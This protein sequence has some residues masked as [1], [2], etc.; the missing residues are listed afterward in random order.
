MSATALVLPGSGSAT[1][2]DLGRFLVLDQYA[3]P[4]VRLA[5]DVLGGSLLAG[6][7]AD[8]EEYGVHG[9]VAFM[10]SSLALAE[11]AERRLGAEP[12]VALGPSLGHRALTAYA[13]VLDLPDAVALAVDFA[14][15][16]AAHFADLA[17]DLVTHCV[18]RVPD[19]PMRALVR[20][21][22]ARGEWIEVAGVLDPGAYLLSLR[23]DLLGELVDRV[24]A[25]GAYS[26]R[27]MRPA[28][29]SRRF[30]GLRE[31]VAAE[32]LPRY[33]L[34]PPALPVV[35]DQDGRVITTAED[36]AAMLL[37]GVDR[38]L[39]WPAAM[40]A[41]AA[42]GVRRVFVTGPDLMFSR[43]ECAAGAFEVTAVTP[44][45]AANPRTTR[46]RVAAAR[47]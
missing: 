23:A 25:L 22:T 18:V 30:A 42:L 16:E 9:A 1:F 17:E 41:C 34:R 46:P 13:G 6:L 20:E 43:L 21:F 28:V 3:R 10:V 45:T 8:G 11:R 35:A 37:D 5:D 26:M 47:D 33:R 36:F 39:D 14:R 2:A 31:V 24:R 29:H 19:E 40:R 12:V 32:V 7:R 27:T 15:C 4:L 38:A 44:K